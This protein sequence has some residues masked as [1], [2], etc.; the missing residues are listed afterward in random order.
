[1]TGYCAVENGMHDIDPKNPVCPAFKDIGNK[2]GGFDL[3]L[4][5]IG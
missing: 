4:I 1:M 2:F 3:G 5:P